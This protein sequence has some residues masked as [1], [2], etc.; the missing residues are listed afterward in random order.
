MRKHGTG[1]L[2]WSVVILLIIAF[3]LTILGSAQNNNAVL[4][5]GIVLWLATCV[6][7]FAW[8]VLLVLTRSKKYSEGPEGDEPRD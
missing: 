3:S 2:F 6:L 5:T 4:I 8:L 7:F 1:I